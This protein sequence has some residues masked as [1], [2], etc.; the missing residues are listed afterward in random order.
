MWRVV[1]VLAIITAGC[2]SPTAPP[3]ADTSRC[4]GVGAALVDAIETGLTLD[5]GSLGRAAAVRS[6]DFDKVWFVAAQ[7]TG[8]GVN[9]VGVWATNSLEAGGGLIF[10]ADGLARGSPGSPRL[11]VV[12]DRFISPR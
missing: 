4:L 1:G 10:A 5:G 8:P 3:A 6:N 11:P 12:D 9:D 2:A 7:I